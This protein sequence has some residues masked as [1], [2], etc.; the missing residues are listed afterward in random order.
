MDES[1]LIPVGRFWL[2]EMQGTEEDWTG[3]IKQHA[4]R[5]IQNRLNQRARRRRMQAAQSRNDQLLGVAGHRDPYFQGSLA[6]LATATASES[7]S[8]CLLGKPEN[9]ELLAKFA[10]QALRSYERGI[11]DTLQLTET[12][13]Y[14]VFHAFVRNAQVLGF[15]DG[16]LL[17]DT[18]SPFNKHECLRSPGFH[19][20]DLPHNMQPT[21]LQV[22]VEH[23][24]W[25][26]F[27]P[28]PRMRDNFLRAVSQYGEEA[29]DED[30]LCRDIVDAGAGAGIESAAILV[31]AES[32]SASGWEV[33]EKFLHKW[34]W[35]L[36]NCV[37][38][39]AATNNWRRKRGLKPLRFPG[40]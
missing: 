18:V 26:D 5:K 29:V 13:R 1:S 25:I 28:C 10:R 36:Y 39:E 15:N 27:F 32:W 17:Y 37:E 30:A 19:P 3:I 9:R 40:C 38:L 20:S 6:A 24:P 4:R 21:L 22:Q 7:Q 8:P 2:P 14:N 12:V 34:S 31:W 33:T 23:H 35:L 16:W 11:L